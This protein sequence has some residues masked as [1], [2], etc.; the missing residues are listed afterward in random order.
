MR[1]YT[2]LILAISLIISTSSLVQ[3]KSSEQGRNGPPQRPTFESIDINEDGEISLD[4]F[5]EQKIPHGD[6][7]TV[8]DLLDTDGDGVISSDEFDN[9][10]PPQRK[11]RRKD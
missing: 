5:S 9:H 3:A 7:E 2:K 4:E 1:P 6:H 8:F 11:N 10:K